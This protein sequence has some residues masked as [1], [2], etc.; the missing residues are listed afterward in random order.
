MRGRPLLA[1]LLWLAWLAPAA[2]ARP[3]IEGLAGPHA[4]PRFGRVETRAEVSPAPRNPFDP[5]EIDVA[6]VFVGPDGREQRALGFWYQDYARELVGG[7]ERLMPLGAPHFRVRFTPDQVGAWRWW[8]EVRTSGGFARSEVHR[9]RMRPSKRHG[10]LRVSPRDP[11][12]LA[13]DDGTPWFA[14]G[15]NLAWYDA[16]GSFA[17]DAWLAALDAEGANFVRLW[18]PS[19]AMGIE[20]SDTGLGDY[21][22]RLDRA[23]QLDVVLAQ[24]EER[25]FQ[26]LLALQ[27]HGAFSTET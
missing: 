15:E 5:A 16:R 26:A 6:G 13:F 22:R 11:R 10:F 7:A 12:Q 19:W 27:N 9:L 23:W 14:V 1:G 4:A 3:R 21:T 17:Y 8:W 25:G 18:M 24:A 20:W 2:A